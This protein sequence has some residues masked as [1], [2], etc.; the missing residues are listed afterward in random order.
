MQSE[1]S[2]TVSTDKSSE[3][4]TQ[5]GQEAPVVLITGA[6]SGIGQAMAR[7]LAAQGYRVFGTGRNPAPAEGYTM[8]PLDVRQ[9]ESVQACIAAVLAQA[10][11]IDVLVNNAGY[12]G[13]VAASEEMAL[14][15]LRAVLETNFFGA[16]RMVNAVL[17]IMREQ[18]HGY[19]VN[20]SSVAGLI[21]LPPFTSA[22]NAS[23]HALEG[24][25]GTLRHEVAPF[26]IR[27]ALIEP[28]YFRSGIG[29]TLETPAN[30]L[31]AY[32]RGRRLNHA[33]ER[34]S[35]NHSDDP[36]K[37]AHLLHRIIE[38]DWPA[39]HHLVSSESHMAFWLS[40]PIG[41]M[42]DV[43]THWLY[44]FDGG[45]TLNAALADDNG[46]PVE[47]T[48]EHFGL[49]RYIFNKDAQRE[50]LTEVGE[51]AALLVGL[52]SVVLIAL[53]LRRSRR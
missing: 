30:P 40:R 5:A 28:G 8:L 26:N 6:S 44:N 39:L 36:I 29:E 19:I 35:G 13:P 22:Y 47:L 1:Y 46:A 45:P 10:G 41:P 23:K 52:G 49:R 34:Y 25:S 20:V 43:L 3:S 14:D 12:V 53:R 50:L 16:V 42:L 17:P 9:D 15:Q 37:V 18:Q 27:V 11:R 33:I 51:A 21:G 38:H 48:T 7:H 31:P 32:A 2:E 4:A 24:Y